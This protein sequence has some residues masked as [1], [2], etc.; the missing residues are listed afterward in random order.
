MPGLIRRRTV[1]RRHFAAAHPDVHR[2][3]AAV[4]DLVVEH[5][6]RERRA[7]HVAH[8][9]RA[10]EELHRAGKI[11]VVRIFQ[12]GDNGIVA[13]VKRIHD[14]SQQM[15]D[16]MSDIIWSVNSSNDLTEQLLV[17]MRQHASDLLEP[18]NI[19]YEFRLDEGIEN[20]KLPMEQRREIFLIFK[21]AV[22]NLCKYAQCRNVIFEMKMQSGDLV[23]SIRDDG[24]GFDPDKDAAGNGLKNMK[25]R[26]RN[27]GGR[28]YI[29]SGKEKGTEIRLQTKIT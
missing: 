3:L 19:N 23:F 18:K 14:S 8:L 2:H 7:R 25:Q 21:E 24:A 28:L 10:G 16:R 27:I 29:E 22:N 17:R 6:V 9:L 20:I 5:E 11:A 26:A 12:L 15:L 4:M 13:L 1:D